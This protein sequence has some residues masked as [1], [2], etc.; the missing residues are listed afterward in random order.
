MT[1][2]SISIDPTDLEFPDGTRYD[3]EKLLASI[4]AYALTVYPDATFTTL[5]IGYRQ[6]DCWERVNG[7]RGL[8]SDLM[9]G[10]WGEH[11]SDDSLF[12][13]ENT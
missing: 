3:E 9:D 10:F 8:G 12:L 2:I 5:Q 7:D 4:R 13:K 11:G 6:G 1:R